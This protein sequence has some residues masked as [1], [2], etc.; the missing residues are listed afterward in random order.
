MWGY[1]KVYKG[2]PGYT[3]VYGGIWR[4]ISIYINPLFRHCFFSTFLDP[5]F[6]HCFFSTF[7]RSTFRLCF[8]ST[9]WWSTLST[10][11]LFSFLR[12]YRPGRHPIFSRELSVECRQNHVWGCIFD[13]SYDHMYKNMYFAKVELGDNHGWKE[14]QQLCRMVFS[15]FTTLAF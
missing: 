9:C 14:C 7:W 4:Y 15:K 5:L 3:K 8:F 13:P 11:F 10:L 1:V 12:V 6:R 2:I